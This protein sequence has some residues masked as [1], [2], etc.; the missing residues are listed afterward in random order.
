MQ[1]IIQFLQY[2]DNQ[3]IQIFTLIIEHIRLTLVAVGAAVAVGVPIGILITY[4]K[5]LN[6]P[7]LG[8][9]NLVQAIPS[10]AL[11]GFAIPFL[12]IGTTPAVFMVILYSLLP[13]VKNTSTGL[14]HINE[15]IIEAAKGIG[16]TKFQ[17]LYKVQIPLALPVIM[18]GVRISAVTAVGLMTIAA[19]VG[20][21]GLGFL[22]FSGIR[23]VNNF[24]I[25]AGAVPAALLALVVDYVAAV[26]ENLVT[27]VSMQSLA[28]GMRPIREARRRQIL[29]LSLA[30]IAVAVFYAKA[31]PT[32]IEQ[33]TITVASKDYTEQDLLCHMMAD[34]IEA[35]TDISVV[36]KL[37][38]GGSVVAFEALRK[39]DIDLL[40]D[41]GGTMY[42]NIL[43]YAPTNDADI[44]YNTSKKDY[45]EK[46]NLEVLDAFAFNNTYTLTVRKD[47]AK[48]YG[49][50][51]ISDLAKVSS[52][53]T[54]AATLEFLNRPD[55]LPGLKE[56]Y[57][58]SFGQELG[59]DSSPRYIAL[60][61]K[62]ADVIDAFSTDGL[63]KKFDLVMLR[64]DKNF[65]LPYFAVPVIRGDVLAKYPEIAPLLNSIA[66]ILT[67]EVMIDLN[68]QVDVLRKEPADVVRAFLIE[69]KL[70]PQ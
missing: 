67:P 33:R 63:I 51:T 39:G 68:Y 42:A 14:D 49:L 56:A 61:N 60:D 10:L 24:Q 5:P 53:L 47:T 3:K 19:F 12:G 23:T 32:K 66:P 35:H 26:V 21:G 64:D 37:G 28:G 65:F 45:K 69:Q 4:V 31:F 52:G 22:V 30:A 17:I 16:L 58:L 18:A 62:K 8:L 13:I 15:Q 6:K 48:Q 46:Y 20:A 25:L 1:V 55:C 70:I 40:A 29:G 38:L 9:A 34:L 54:L 36:R 57:G 44:V 41:Y 59:V 7:I 27:P 2:I 50:K 11:L 43:K